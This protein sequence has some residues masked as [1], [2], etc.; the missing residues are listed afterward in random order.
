MAQ[1]VSR[2]PASTPSSPTS[3]T[4]TPSSF[5]KHLWRLSGSKDGYVLL[6]PQDEPPP[7]LGYK[8]GLHACVAPEGPWAG[9]PAPTPA[10]PQ[11]CSHRTAT[12]PGRG[13]MGHSWE[14]SDL[15]ISGAQGP[16]TVS[17]VSQ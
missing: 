12:P 4:R 16:L 3:A 10:A 5:L 15:F 17:Q 8:H 1:E 14:G 9:T 7:S 11:C 13:I 6:L 2:S